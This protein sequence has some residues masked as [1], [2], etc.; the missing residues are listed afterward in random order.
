MNVLK[1]AKYL[2]NSRQFVK[3]IRLLEPLALNFREN[4]TYYYI[5][6]MACLY[7]GDIGSA[8]V[9]FNRA[10]KLRVQ[11][12][13]LQ[14]AQ[15]AVFMH[16]NDGPRAIGYYLDV[17]DYAPN[18]KHAKKCLTMLK[19]NG[20]QETIYEWINSGKIKR[21]FP[22]L[23]TNPKIYFVLFV[24]AV[25]IVM[26]IFGYFAHKKAN[27]FN[28]SRADWSQ[29]EL[30]FEEKKSADSG[31]GIAYYEFSERELVSMYNQIQKNYNKFNDNGAQINCNLIIN[32]NASIALKEKAKL[33]S[34]HLWIPEP[35]FDS[36]KYNLTYEQVRKEP[37]RYNNCRVIWSGRIS[38][39]QILED[40][41]V[42]E[43]LVGYDNLTHIAGV[44][45][46]FFAK[47]VVPDPQKS[48]KILGILSI[49]DGKMI[50][51][52]NAIYQ[53]LV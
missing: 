47:G 4:F 38:N 26:S 8:E 48:V 12:P 29:Y 53:P 13:N 2:L 15:A 51:K 32:S 18:N 23:E 45:S 30:S 3:V 7:N 21:Y 16:R 34:T 11:D 33:L 46:V 9:Y 43:L 35:T 40:K 6:G 10:R 50:L 44:I 19:K 28:G 1:K 24:S 22:P 14:L 31:K 27:S 36:L 39:I 49:E 5:L 52:A 37:F 42:G 25:L 17:L 20:S 41:V